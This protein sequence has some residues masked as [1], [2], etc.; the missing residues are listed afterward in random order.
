MNA[1]N[2]SCQDLG[3]LV[4][5]A[6]F[7]V[8]HSRAA[9]WPS[10]W[11]CWRKASFLAVISWTEGMGRTCPATMT[12]TLGM[13]MTMMTQAKRRTRKLVDERDVRA[14]TKRPRL[15]KTDR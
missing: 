12:A 4:A 10:V 11:T 5:S 6:W 7:F 13:T 2:L 1:R 15:K 8:T 14:E 9:F 3:S